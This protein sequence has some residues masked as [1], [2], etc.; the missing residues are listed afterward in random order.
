MGGEPTF[1]GE[2]RGETESENNRDQKHILSL[3]LLDLQ[4][5]GFRSLRCLLQPLRLIGITPRRSCWNWA[6]MPQPEFPLSLA[7][8]VAHLKQHFPE[9]QR[10]RLCTLGGFY[11]CVVFMPDGFGYVGGHRPVVTLR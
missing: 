6:A 8:F 10:A 11:R 9:V 1:W 4:T 7:E 5:F 3:E 2:G